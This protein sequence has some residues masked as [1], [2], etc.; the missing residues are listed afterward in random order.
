PESAWKPEPSVTSPND[1]CA[2]HGVTWRR[3]S[4]TASTVVFGSAA[5][6][7]RTVTRARATG[8]TA[9]TAPDTDGTSSPVTVIAYEDHRR[10]ASEPEP[11]SDTP[12]RTPAVLRNSSSVGPCPRKVPRGRPGTRTSPLSSCR[13]VH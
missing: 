5:G 11:T 10:S 7:T 3:K 9:L 4:I 12:S 6:G 1:T 8:C 13:A 2:P